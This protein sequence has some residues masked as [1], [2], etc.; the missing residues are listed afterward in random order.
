VWVVNSII[1]FLFLT[2]TLQGRVGTVEQE[3]ILACGFL[4]R[5][6][7]C[8]REGDLAIWL[9]NL[10]VDWP[11]LPSRPQFLV[12]GA[13][14]IMWFIEFEWMLYYMEYLWCILFYHYQEK[15]KVKK[16]TI[17]YYT[18]VVRKK[19]SRVDIISRF[20]NQCLLRS[21]SS[22]I[23]S[24]N[25]PEISWCLRGAFFLPLMHRAIPE[26]SKRTRTYLDCVETSIIEI[27]ETV[28]GL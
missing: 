6:P 23:Y 16:N 8:S 2:I 25:V 12:I 1:C 10:L 11:R 19:R 22:S 14:C 15:R 7:Y 27:I 26:R 13:N 21:Y 3:N 4:Y 18:C 28:I 24:D 17:W 20:G 5:G 9:V